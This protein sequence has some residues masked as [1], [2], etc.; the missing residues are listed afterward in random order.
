MTR[1][2]STPA[3]GPA[4]D[5]GPRPEARPG[6][7]GAE[8]ADLARVV[9]AAR[10]LV[11]QGNDVDLTGL[12][13]RTETVCRAI[14]MAAV[15]RAAS[16]VPSITTL[17]DELDRLKGDLTDRQRAYARAMDDTA[18]RRSATRA[19]TNHRPKPR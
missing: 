4:S 16:L 6:D 17:L 12:E 1:P 19:Y 13:A 8:I 2:R 18:A 9:A 14:S 5:G 3:R 15:E 7:P 10:A 11:A